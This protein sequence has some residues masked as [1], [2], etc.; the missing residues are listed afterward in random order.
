MNSPQTMKHIAKLAAGS[1]VAVLIVD[2]LLELKKLL[3]RRSSSTSAEKPKFLSP[4]Q[5]I[6]RLLRHLGFAYG[7]LGALNL[8]RRYSNPKMIFPL[9]FVTSLLLTEL[10][11]V[12]L[13]LAVAFYVTT[14]TLVS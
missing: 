7:Q 6:L 4:K 5:F 13:P 1:G 3:P 11:S 8:I 10:C 14:R 9:T 2:I 12:E